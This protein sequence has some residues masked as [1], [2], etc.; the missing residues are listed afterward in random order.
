MRLLS[1]FLGLLLPLTAHAACEGRDLR[2]DLSTETQAKL[3]DTLSNIPF[4]E[5]NHWIATKDGTVLH[6]I[7]T[8]HTNDERMGPVVD[9]LAPVLS[10]ADAFYFEVIK[11][12][13]D[14]FEKDL[15]ND[16]SP[17]L[18]TSGPT[19][20]DLMSEEDWAALSA[21]LAERGIPSWMAA[22]MRPWFLSMMLGIPP[23]LMKTPNFDRGMDTRLTELAE[24]HD[25]PQYSLE[26]IE[27]LIAL[28]DSHSLEE[29]VASLTR[30]SG[31]L[32]AGDDQ[33]ITMANAYIDEQHAAIMELAK[34]QGLEASGLTPEEFDTEWQNFEDQL[35]VQRNAKW[36]EK[37][38]KLKDQTVVIA[39]G[40]GHLS[41]DYGL[42]NQ[43]QQAGYNLERA[44]F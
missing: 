3:D 43:L 26:R 41:N 5:G 42:L 35:L 40:A 11:D 33:M 16:F 39:V 20:V 25:I 27:D 7:G 15:A 8:L 34:I 24:E 2:L 14:A 36:M 13:M 31:A 6:L 10:Q 4:P 38:L 44:K 1:I 19:L 18:I 37:I 30:L 21:T 23:C 9:R 22:K 17:V 12:E 32:Q 28:F 29:Q